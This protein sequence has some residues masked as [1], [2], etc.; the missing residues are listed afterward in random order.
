MS[1]DRVWRVNLPFPPSANTMFRNLSDAER[2]RI[3][4]GMA[5]KGKRGMP[6][7]RSP[8]ARYVEWRKVAHTYIQLSKMPRFD[9]PVV[10]TIILTPP[11]NRNSD[12]DNR[13]KPVMDALKN[14]HILPDDSNRWVYEIRVRWENPDDD[15]PRAAVEIR[16]APD[17]KPA[18]SASARRELKTICERDGIRTV[19]AAEKTSRAIRELIAKGY[20]VA[21]PGLLDGSQQA[22]KIA[23]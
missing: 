11:D 21:E 10:V 20:L 8:D 12:A 19:G 6:P 7:T 18:L 16:L 14:A 15:E 4:A 13:V 17:R 5:R 23:N 9:R 1:D 3:A 22:Y 2:S